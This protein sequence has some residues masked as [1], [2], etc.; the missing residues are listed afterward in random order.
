VYNPD[1]PPAD[2]SPAPAATVS[3][4]AAG[5]QTPVRQRASSLRE[6]AELLE[7]AQKAL[8]DKN[9]NLADLLFSSAELIAGAPAVS[10]LATL[11]RAGAPPRIETPTI[12]VA[13]AGK[14]PVAVG[15]TEEEDAKEAPPKEEP[16]RGSLEGEVK[17]GSGGAT[18]ALALVTLDPIGRKGKVRTPK[19]R[20]V[21]QRDRQFAPRLMVVPVGSTVS[22]PNF[23]TIFHNVFSRDP[24]AAFDLG[25][26]KSGEAREVIFDK[27]GIVRLGCNLHGN[28][29]ATI[30]VVGSSHYVIAEPS[31]AFRF[32][33]LAPGKYKLRAWSE[34]SKEPITQEITIKAGANKLSVGVGADGAA[35]MMVD[36]FGVARAK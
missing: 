14:Q 2:E 35:G 9:R 11:F 31:G 1:Y 25:L 8:D 28:M 23:D 13:D 10:S 7:K 15:S 30:V 26:Y 32:R 16:E 33:S 21:E 4:A 18:G 17:I 19:Q 5:P 36:K 24:A 12:K 27:E 20:I 22:F 6:A 3:S 29:S 34:R